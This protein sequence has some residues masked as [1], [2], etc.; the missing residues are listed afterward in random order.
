[1]PSSAQ[2]YTQ[3]IDTLETLAGVQRVVQC[4]G[5]FATASCI[6]CRVRVPGTEIADD[7]MNQRVPLCKICNAQQP[8]AA[9][10]KA[11][12]KKAKKRKDGWDSD[13][14]DEPDVPP[15][16]PGVMKAGETVALHIPGELTRSL[17]AA[18][19]HLLW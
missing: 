9:T 1:M 7:I 4:H 19:Y 13:Q 2:N 11:A 8:P 3:N 6:N 5:S 18:R 17:R 15:Y 16:P 10:G 12:K 14:S